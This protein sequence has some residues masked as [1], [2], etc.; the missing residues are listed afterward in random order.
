MDFP[1]P[2]GLKYC[3]DLCK[4][5]PLCY[6]F[7]YGADDGWCRIHKFGTNVANRNGVTTRR[8]YVVCHS[9]TGSIINSGVT[10][11]PQSDTKTFALTGASTV[12]FTKF[13]EYSSY[14]AYCPMTA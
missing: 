11:A 5:N 10:A 13:S 9:L 3:I 4:T 7:H 2:S 6:A 1:D 8:T 14:S 12:A